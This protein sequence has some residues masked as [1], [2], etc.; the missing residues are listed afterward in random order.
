MSGAGVNG[1]IGSCES[2]RASWEYLSE[3]LNEIRIHRDSHHDASISAYSGVERERIDTAKLLRGLRPCSL[4]GSL[5][6]IEAI[7]NRVAG[8]RK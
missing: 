1:C 6:S 5:S 3:K 8:R 2:G 7:A 4:Q